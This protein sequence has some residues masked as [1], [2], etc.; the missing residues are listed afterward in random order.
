M[1][2]I[3]VLIA[4]DHLL[5]RETLAH[6]LTKHGGFSVET[7]A[8]LSETLEKITEAGPFQ[9]VLLDVVMPGMQGLPSITEVVARNAGG[10]VAVM[11]GMIQRE[12]AEAAIQ[13]GAMGYIPKTLPIAT[14]IEALISLSQGKPYLP[15]ELHA[16]VPR[17]MPPAL[18]AL[19]P[20]E[21]RVL[22]FLCQGMSNKEIARHMSIGEVTIKT[23]MRA[24]CLK[25]GVRNR[26]EAALLGA[27]HLMPSGPV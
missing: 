14:L 16:N 3:S 10:A 27:K 19:S 25:L 12:F 26:T 13:K 6:A 20:T 18:A 21:A 1:S 7:A 9:V 15:F 23:H 11:S 22:R 24:I 8:S 2:V 17:S 5:L 4:D